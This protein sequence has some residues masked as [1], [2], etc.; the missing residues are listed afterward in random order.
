MDRPT[1][2]LLV[3]LRAAKNQEYLRLAYKNLPFLSRFIYRYI[4][5]FLP[6]KIPSSHPGGHPRTGAR[7]QARLPA[8]AAQARGV[9]QVRA[10]HHGR[11]AAE[12]RWVPEMGAHRGGLS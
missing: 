2:R 10:R 11:L 12:R 9:R 8:L 7:L 1:T 3:L 5:A 4:I 6:N